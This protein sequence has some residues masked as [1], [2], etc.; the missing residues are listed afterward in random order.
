[1]CSGGTCVGTPV[2]CAASDQCHTAGTCDASTGMCTN[3]SQPN[4][5]ACNDGMRCTTNDAC[6]G[7]ACVGRPTLCSALDECHVAGT[8]Q[9]TT[10]ACND[11]LAPDG[12]G[13]SLFTGSGTCYQGTCCA[14]VGS[15]Q[16][17]PG[18]CCPAGSPV[19]ACDN[20]LCQPC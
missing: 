5:H 9:E 19:D 13:C 11:P 7:G 12:K 18:W 8:C 4:E 16:C 17:D 14:V 10:G 6:S 3:P 1:A 20:C 2:V 15:R